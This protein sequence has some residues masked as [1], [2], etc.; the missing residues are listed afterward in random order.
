MRRLR[1]MLRSRWMLVLAPV[2][3]I[4]GVAAYV[5]LLEQP[6]LRST[7]LPAWIGFAAGSAL[8]VLVLRARRG[9]GAWIALGACVALAGMFAVGFCFGQRLPS[10]QPAA[11]RSEW[12]PPRLRL[13]AAM[14]SFPMTLPRCR[15]SA[16]RKR[17]R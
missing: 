6:F 14:R 15:D 13:G 5:A 17:R 1:R 8:A 3:C 11:E 10:A 7:A 12:T 4:A 2:L 9:V 16:V